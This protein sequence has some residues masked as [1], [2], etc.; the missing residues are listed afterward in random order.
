VWVE[1]APYVCARSALRAEPNAWVAQLS[2]SGPHSL[3]PDQHS[4][5]PM[6]VRNGWPVAIL[7]RW[8]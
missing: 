8:C 2:K 3:E 1:V 5:R 6:K 7:P 4:L